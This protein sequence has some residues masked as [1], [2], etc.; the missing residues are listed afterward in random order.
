MYLNRHLFKYKI[1]KK[2][3][4]KIINSCKNEIIDEIIHFLSDLDLTELNEICLI[5]K[6]YCQS[7]K[8]KR[9][10]IYILAS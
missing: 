1:L 4:K 6:G 8:H 2:Q 10:E 7:L 9:K 3:Y 5:I